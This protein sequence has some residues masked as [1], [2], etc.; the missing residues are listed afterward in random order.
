MREPAED[1]QIFR[2]TIQSA[3]RR[4][5]EHSIDEVRGNVDIHRYTRYKLCNGCDRNKPLE[6]RKCGNCSS[7]EFRD[8]VCKNSTRLLWFMD[9]LESRH[10][11]P[12]SYHNERSCRSVAG[13]G[14]EQASCYETSSCGFNRRCPLVTVKTALVEN[15]RAILRQSA[16]LEIEN[17]CAA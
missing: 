16:G 6:T 7:R 13:S 9:W 10:Y 1:V 11:W 3:I 14:E 4:N 2:E 12:L 8:E 5:I 17:Y 15:I